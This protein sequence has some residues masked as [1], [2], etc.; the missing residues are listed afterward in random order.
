L[1][2]FT[3]RMHHNTPLKNGL[4]QGLE[5]EELRNLNRAV[6]RPI[7]MW[8][9][10]SHT[11]ERGQ[12]VHIPA[13]TLIAIVSSYE[14]ILAVTDGIVPLLEQDRRVGRK[15]RHFMFQHGKPCPIVTEAGSPLAFLNHEHLHRVLLQ[16]DA[17]AR[18]I[19][20]RRG[21][22]PEELRDMV[23][24]YRLIRCY[25]E[26]HPTRR[27]Y[28]QKWDVYKI[29]ETVTQAPVRGKQ[30]IDPRNALTLEYSLQC[31]PIFEMRP[32]QGFTP[33]LMRDL[34]KFMG[35]D[36]PFQAETTTAYK[37]KMWM[38]CPIGQ[39]HQMF[40]EEERER[41][42]AIIAS[43]E[44]LSKMPI[45]QLFQKS[46]Q[47]PQVP[48]QSARRHKPRMEKRDSLPHHD[49][50]NQNRAGVEPSVD[51]SFGGFGLASPFPEEAS[52]RTPAS[53]TIAVEENELPAVGLFGIAHLPSQEQ[54]EI[55]RNVRDESPCSED[56]AAH[57]EVAVPFCGW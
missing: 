32:D 10:L 20:Q 31:P 28:V 43:G 22:L 23:A 24:G 15:N 55:V 17:T 41:R 46:G 56:D 26:K 44:N 4:F 25:R 33:Q 53:T 47:A 36:E 57:E 50:A 54:Y 19:L 38:A 42:E 9:Y 48:Q 3:N 51:T 39:F 5:T 27:A 8:S 2:F 21:A 13:A 7:P 12:R 6:A 40:E 34:A 16:N 11:N 37:Y 18:K 35:R 29:D 30:L 52:T 14:T 49:R 1:E 45:R